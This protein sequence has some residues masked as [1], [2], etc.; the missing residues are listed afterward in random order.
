MCVSAFPLEACG[1]QSGLK[2]TVPSSSVQKQNN[3][4][5]QRSGEGLSGEELEVVLGKEALAGELGIHL[6]CASGCR[7]E[8]H[9]KPSV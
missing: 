7:P 9:R 4:V 2:A 5:I 6:S 1:L 8:C 3:E